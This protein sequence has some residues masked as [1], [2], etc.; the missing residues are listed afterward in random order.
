MQNLRQHELVKPCI[1]LMGEFSAGKSTLANLMM[2]ANPLPVQAI[3]TRLPPVRMS[4]GNGRPYRLDTDGA[5]HTVDLN[6]LSQIPLET[7]QFL[8]IFRNETTL[9]RCDLIDMPGISDPNMSAESWRRVLPSADAVIWCT[10][11]TQAWRQS[12]AAVWTDVPDDI[13][14]RSILL[15]TRIDKIAQGSD[16]IRVV[17][18]VKNEAGENFA[19]CMPISLT[20]AHAAGDDLTAWRKSGAGDF[21]TAFMQLIDKVTAEKNTR[22]EQVETPSVGTPARP[23]KKPIVPRRIARHGK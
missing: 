1:A 3:A 21:A 17:Q 10:H 11:A 13:K 15:I 2:E 19:R 7:T 8:Q 18:R 5:K 20:D 14:A 22:S 23:T 4:Y 9:E 12:E 6:D 16:R